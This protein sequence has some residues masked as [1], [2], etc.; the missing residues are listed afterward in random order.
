MWQAAPIKTVDLGP[1]YTDGILH[2]KWTAHAFDLYSRLSGSA[3]AMEI[4]INTTHERILRS[5]LTAAVHFQSILAATPTAQVRTAWPWLHCLPSRPTQQRSN[6]A[7]SKSIAS[8]KNKVAVVRATKCSSENYRMQWWEL[9]NAVMRATK[10]SGENYKM[11]WWE[12]QNAVVRA[13]KCSG[14]NYKMESTYSVYELQVNYTLQSTSTAKWR[15][16]IAGLTSQ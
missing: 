8:L 6:D 12:L 2:L 7:S 11:Q 10:C 9:Q 15:P 14:E 1:E 5:W 4:L 16:C 13:T 3:D